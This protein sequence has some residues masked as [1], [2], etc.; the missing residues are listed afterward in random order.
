MLKNLV[1]IVALSVIAFAITGCG[2][3]YI[4]GNI[5][6][7]SDSDAVKNNNTKLYYEDTNDV[8]IK[9]DIKNF[10]SFLNRDSI[11]SEFIAV[12]KSNEEVENHNDFKYEYIKNTENKIFNLKFFVDKESNFIVV[13]KH[14]TS[15]NEAYLDLNQIRAFLFE[16]TNKNPQIREQINCSGDLVYLDE[17]ALNNGQLKFTTKREMSRKF[18]SEKIKKAYSNSGYKMVN[19]PKEADKIVYFQLTRDYKKSEIEKLKEQGKGINFGVIQSGM[20]NQ[21][22]LMQNSMNIASHNNSS[23]SSVGIALGMGLVLG[24]LS[25]DKDPNFIVPA[26]KVVDV[27]QNKSYLIDTGALTNLYMS[28]NGDL[29][30]NSNELN[31]LFYSLKIVNNGSGTYKLIPLN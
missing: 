9:E 16:Q 21:V 13:D 2:P 15:R 6:V 19:N 30:F 10:V 24:L 29:S 25:Y 20:S 31:S 14:Y 5:Q 23:S 3:K 4:D 8:A 28:R 7:P 27:K 1:K 17:R 26:I 11:S 22:N 12:S 18:L